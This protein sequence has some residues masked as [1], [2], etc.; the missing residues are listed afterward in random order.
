MDYGFAACAALRH[1]FSP[2]EAPRLFQSKQT[3]AMDLATEEAHQRPGDLDVI[4]TRGPGTQ[5]RVA[6]GDLV[7]TNLVC[8]MIKNCNHLCDFDR[9]LWRLCR[10]NTTLRGPKR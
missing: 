8:Q 2:V 9:T 4:K 5:Q 6:G 3:G 1:P 10:D 7:S